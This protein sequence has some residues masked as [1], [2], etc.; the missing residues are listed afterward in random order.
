MDPIQK[1]KVLQKCQISPPPDTKDEE[2]TLP[3]T[4]LD[5]PWLHLYKMQSLLL[6]DFPHP[7]TH[8]LDTIIPNLKSSL[9]LTLKHYLPLAGNLLMP[10]K[11]GKPKLHY[12]LADGDTFPLI[13][14][15]SAQDFISLKGH[16]PRNS[17]DLHAL[18]PVMPRNVRT[19]SDCKV[20]PLMAV[21]VTVFPS[22]GIAIGLTTHH[23]VADAK[24]IVD[25]MNAWA[26]VNKLGTDEELSY[27]NLI[28]SFDRSIIHDPCGLEDTFWN[29]MQDVLELFSRF[30]SGPP[31]FNK[32]RVTF[33]LTPVDIQRLKNKVLNLRGLGQQTRVTTFTVTCGYVWTCMLKSKDAMLEEV[34]PQ[35][36]ENE[37]EYFSFTANCRALLRPPAPANYFGNCIAPCLAKA[38]HGELIGSEGFL[39]ATAA[40][41][42]AIDKRV[43]NKEGVLADA[44]TWLTE[45]KGILSERLLGV[46]GS[47]RFDSYGVDFGWGKPEKYEITS[48]DYAGLMSLIKS[49]EFEGGVEVG[50]SL[51]KIQMNAFARIFEEGL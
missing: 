1:V 17:N 14:S 20:I 45:S 27:T 44:K 38:R 33:V 11:T 29:Q 21:Q 32:V 48:I 10:I 46:S 23:C 41:G 6:Y 22:H 30:G 42:E 26:S 50:L 39:V 9:S 34:P 36:D 12:S 43:N 28:P 18:L 49:R 25:F 7:K 2:L 35:N 51:P 19:T 8:F 40:V 4:F 15:E 16:Q 37:I 13:F 31:Q 3:I 5:I 24:S 47:P